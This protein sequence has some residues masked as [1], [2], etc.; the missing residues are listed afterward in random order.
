[1]KT[2]W[3]IVRNVKKNGQ[4]CDQKEDFQ[5]NCVTN[6]ITPYG[7][8]VEFWTTFILWGRWLK[9]LYQSFQRRSVQISDIETEQK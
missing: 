6:E 5:K 3:F 7:F 8:A 2:M 1:M 9:A 4:F